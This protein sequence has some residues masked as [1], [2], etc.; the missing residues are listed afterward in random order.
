MGFIVGLAPALMFWFVQLYTR[1]VY[2]LWAALAIAGLVVIRNVI[3]RRSRTFD[4]IVLCV[5]AGIAFWTFLGGT[6]P[7]LAGA[8]VSAGL[9]LAIMVSIVAGRPFTC[10]YIRPSEGAEPV[11][12]ETFLAVHKHISLAWAAVFAL[13]IPIQIFVAQ[14]ML[15]PFVFGRLVPITLIGAGLVLSDWYYDRA[16]TR[17][18]PGAPKPSG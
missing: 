14:D 3:V 10:V 18:G 11:A 7:R 2:A 13:L 9:F 17:S 4:V 15:G 6:L 8:M 12:H 5:F 16:I 1:P